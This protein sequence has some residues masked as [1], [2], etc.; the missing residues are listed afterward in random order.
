MPKKDAY[1][2]YA[3]CAHCRGGPPAVA[4][5]LR[6]FVGEEAVAR[7]LRSICEKFRAA[8]A[9]G[10]TWVATFLSEGDPERSAR[11]QQDA[12]MTVHEVCRLLG[13]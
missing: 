8:E 10:P 2:I 7:G 1:D 3:L 6:P 13:M 12:F 4:E 11:F 5:V 9:E